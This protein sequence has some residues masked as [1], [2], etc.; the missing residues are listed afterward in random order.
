MKKS[1]CITAPLSLFALSCASVVS[2]QSLGSAFSYQG[3]LKEAGV[4]T[5]GLYDIQA[6]LFST[7]SGATSLL[8]CAPDIPDVPVSG[9]LFTVALDFG[10]T[11]FVGQQQR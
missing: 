4:P 7:F 11:V 9:G 6:C 10:A 5:S 2:A 8:Q 1:F 3:Q